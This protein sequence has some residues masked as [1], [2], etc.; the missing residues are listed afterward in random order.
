MILK[1]K[2]V[3]YLKRFS[4]KCVLPKTINILIISMIIYYWNTIFHEENFYAKILVFLAIISSLFTYIILTN[5]RKIA[6]S[7]NLEFNK[8]KIKFLGYVLLII[9]LIAHIIFYIPNIGK[10]INYG[11]S[12]TIGR[13]NGF[14]TVFFD[15]YIVGLLLLMEYYKDKKIKGT[16]ILI[17]LIAPYVIF[18]MF[19][20]MK[21]RQLI[22]IALG[23]I[24]I[25]FNNFLSKRKGLL[26]IGVL[27]LYVLFSIFGKS[28]GAIDLLGLSGG[29]SYIMDNFTF[30]W[31]SISNFEG[32][33]MS[34][35]LNDI[36]RFV[37][38]DG[39]DIMVLLGAITIFI[40]RKLFGFKYLA[41]PEWYTYNFHYSMYSNGTGYAGSMVGEAYLIGHIPFIIILFGFIGILTIII[42]KLYLKGYRGVYAICIYIMFLLPRLDL[43]SLNIMLIFLIIPTI[44]A[45]KISIVKVG[46]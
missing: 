36:I 18:Y 31:I 13:G 33:Y 20:L 42:D 34:M 25:V 3:D 5:R 41:F 8:E 23:L 35:I 38:Y 1:Y 22:L 14:I 2:E 17:T 10:I 40:P 43:G 30:E 39:I 28:R 45:Y 21:R 24:I 7:Y 12:Y 32:K 19:F 16:F 44:I 46:D 6:I 29:I 11:D 4:N 37:E 15:F 26:Y 27:I 9:G